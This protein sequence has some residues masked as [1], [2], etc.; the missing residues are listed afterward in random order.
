M[1][2]VALVEDDIALRDRVLLPSLR[3]A[4][5]DVRPMALAAELREHL[6]HEAVDIAVLDVGLPDGDG[7]SLS[8]HCREA[9]P[10]MG[11][12]MLTGRR[13]TDDV[14]RGL[15]DADAYLTKPVSV[16]VLVATLGSVARR[17]GRLVAPPPAEP[18]RLVGSQWALRSPAGVRIG[19]T[20]TERTFLTVLFDRVDE[21]VPRDDL[22][23][24]MTDNVHDYDPH[25][26]D[27]LLHRLRRKIAAATDE[28]FPLNPVH[29]N[30]Y[31]L[32]A[33]DT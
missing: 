4:G 7:F 5:F 30:G 8:K 24:A 2:S 26:L 28:R 18:W 11:I 25:R 1:I 27:S 12:V 14:V 17:L 16:D 29:G 21:T 32:V 20:A 6:S 31:M 10:D 23:Q 22:V 33:T 9:R 15:N 3:R 19:L 13:D